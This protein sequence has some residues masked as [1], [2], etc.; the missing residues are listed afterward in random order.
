VAYEPPSL[1]GKT[2]KEVGL[3]VISIDWP[4]QA[5]NA[6]ARSGRRPWFRYGWR[7]V[8]GGIGR[9]FITL[10]MLLFGFVGYQLWGTGIQTAHAQGNLRAAFAAAQ[11]NTPARATTSAPTSA[12]VTTTTAPV[13]GASTTLTP[14][15]TA[16]TSTTTVA[17]VMLP[18]PA[19][20]A[21]VASLDIPR[22]GLK[23]SIIVSGV[24]VDDLKK[25]VGQFRTSPLPGQRG[26]A[27]F[28]GHRTTSGH[29]F[30]RLDELKVGDPI[31]FTNA[32]GET[33]VYKMTTSL[34]V[35][36]NDV[37]VLAAT[38][39]PTLTLV[40]CTPK[41]TSTNRLVIHA[42]LDLSASTGPVREPT[43]PANGVPD[44]MPDETTTTV[45]TT[46]VAA[47]VTNVAGAVVTMTIAA[48]A[49]TVPRVLTTGDS[50]SEAA[51]ARTDEQLNGAFTQGWFSDKHA[52]PQVILWG[53]ICGLIALGAWLLGRKLHRRFVGYLVGVFPFLFTL[54][55]FYEN[56]NR[57]LPPGL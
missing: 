25:G 32:F 38:D 52:I 42:D 35:D 43:P 53:L 17:T 40:T 4:L 55:F 2:N 18:I 41:Y 50:A 26:N 19:A 39:G 49:T 7:S 56:V 36:P 14:L 9:L 33:Y 15:T 57:L 5:V 54:Y 1:A 24:T 10:G 28:A 45:E 48:V 51:N 13:A 27:A 23:N 46:T 8:I 37:T 29:P 47:P 44:R 12:P 34:V 16:A 3:P 30:E 31:M 20:G 11:A 6:S 22:I 21:A